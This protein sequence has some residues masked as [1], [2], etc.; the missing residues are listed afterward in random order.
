M[1]REAPFQKGTHLKEKHEFWCTAG[2]RRAGGG[3][4]I[5]PQ[6][7]SPLVRGQALQHR[8]QRLPAATSQLLRGG[9]RQA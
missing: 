3:L 2:W 5:S 8:Y 4:R 7:S 6:L 1:S 9:A